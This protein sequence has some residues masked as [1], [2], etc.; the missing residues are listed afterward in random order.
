M[1]YATRFALAAHAIIAA[2]N[3]VTSG[4]C[5]CQLT[6]VT[7]DKL[8]GAFYVEANINRVDDQINSSASTSAMGSSA[9]EALASIIGI[10]RDAGIIV[11]GRA[12]FNGIRIRAKQGMYNLSFSLKTTGE[13]LLDLAKVS[14]DLLLLLSL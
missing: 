9:N 6:H 1:Q 5:L 13:S 3:I 8:T 4:L 14:V 12:H 7:D 2:P 10:T 11:D